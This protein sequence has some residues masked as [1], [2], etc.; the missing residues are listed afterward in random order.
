MTMYRTILLLAGSVTLA[1]CS[2]PS[3]TCADHFAG[4]ERPAIT[5]PSLAGKT[6]LLCYEGYAVTHSGVSRTPMWTAEQLTTDRIRAAEALKRKNAFHA[7]EQLPPDE[8]AELADYAHSGFDR[9]HMAPSGDMATEQSQYESFSLANMIPQDPNNNQNLWA[10]IEQATRHLAEREG[11][12]YVITGPIFEGASLQRLNGRVLVPTAVYKALYVP[13]RN[14]AGAYVARNA[15][16][17]EYQTVSIAEL[18]QQI[19]ISLFP[20]L[21]PE[22]KQTKMDMPVPVPHRSKKS[23][24][25]PTEVESLTR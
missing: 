23:R 19:N 14:A 8:R 12:V 15:P 21:P 25:A 3:P 4:G 17:M 1:S 13:S 6:R 18:E 16:G 9:G 10:A 2:T 22:V 7:E 11:T 20:G 24:N 5:S